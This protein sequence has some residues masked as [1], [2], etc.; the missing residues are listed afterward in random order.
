VIR[1]SSFVVNASVHLAAYILG[2]V[3]PWLSPSRGCQPALASVH[4]GHRARVG[5]EIARCRGYFRSF[6]K[7]LCHIA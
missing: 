1:H 4:P 6:P 5:D 2:T 7:N 3:S